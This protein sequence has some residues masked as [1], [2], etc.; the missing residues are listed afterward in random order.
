MGPELD[1]R[2]GVDQAS[3]RQLG[4]EH[5]GVREGV[6]GVAGVTDYERGSVE[7]PTLC[8]VRRRPPEDDSLEHRAARRWIL[9]YRIET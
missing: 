8:P 5:V 4:G 7:C 1:D 9:R 3:V 2:V 6:D